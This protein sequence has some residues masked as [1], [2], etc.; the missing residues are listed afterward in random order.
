VQSIRTTIAPRKSAVARR[1]AD[2]LRVAGFAVFVLGLE[3]ILARGAVGESALKYLILLGGA[4][5]AAAILR[6]PM[7]AALVYFAF[8]DFIFYPLHFAHQVGGLNVR[9]YEVVLL[10]L[11]ILAVAR[12][13]RRTWGGF[14]GGA[15]AVF[16]LCLLLASIFALTAGHVESTEAF[17]WARPMT[18]LA[19]F[20]V[21]LRLFPTPKDRETLL[22]GLAIIAAATG[23]FALLIFAGAGLGEYLQEEANAIREQGSAERVR[24]PGLSAGYGLFWYAA[25]QAA[26]RE[27]RGRFWWLVIFAGISADIIVS[28]NR[29]MW[30]G[31]LLGFVVMMAVGTVRF[32]KQV[33]FGMLVLLTAIT[34]FVLVGGTAGNETI[35]PVIERGQTL[36][37]PGKTSKESSLQSRALETKIAWGEVKKHPLLGVGPGAPFGVYLLEGVRGRDGAVIGYH[38]QPQLFLHNQYIYLILIAGIP[39]LI[40]FILF[41][42]SAVVR[43]IRRRPKD[44]AIVACGVGVG[45]IMV[46]SF[47]AIYFSVVDMTVVLG[48]LTGVIVASAEE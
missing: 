29:N 44:L 12:P 1:V 33:V 46:S 10:I 8:T 20:W 5:V 16:F 6:F 38:H 39:G 36:V 11:F 45:M 30:V 2:P 14:T 35:E 13:K 41:L 3:L 26:Q 43:A 47:V 9:P 37:N 25:V 18:L 24:L 28:F 23:V 27:G 48:L 17:N 32:R 21:V 31:I 19:F 34:F 7:Q 15:L 4:F 22:T 40:A 42:G